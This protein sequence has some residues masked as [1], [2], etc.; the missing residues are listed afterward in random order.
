MESHKNNVINV[1]E[2]DKKFINA[3]TSLSP[4][5]KILIKGILI[6]MDLQEKPRLSPLGRW[7]QLIIRP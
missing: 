3:L 1:H 7:K 6:G 4:E 5:K 2:E